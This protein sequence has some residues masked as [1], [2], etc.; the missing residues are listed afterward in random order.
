MDNS[1][2]LTVSLGWI[3]SL[4]CA[5]YMNDDGAGGMDSK[6]NTWFRPQTKTICVRCRKI[7]EIEKMKEKEL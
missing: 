6:G 1:T 4:P 2:L 5:C 7:D 3:K